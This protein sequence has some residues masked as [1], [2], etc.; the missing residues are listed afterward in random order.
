[1]PGGELAYVAGR[2]VAGAVI[3]H[4][5]FRVPLLRSQVFQDS[6]QRPADA[7]P[8]VVS[9]YNNAVLRLCRLQT[10]IGQGELYRQAHA[11]CSFFLSMAKNSGTRLGSQN[12]FTASSVMVRLASSWVSAGLYG[13]AVRNA[14]YTSTT[15]STRASS[16]MLYPVSWSG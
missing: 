14:S 11:A 13:R 3:H 8:L 15:C 1:M 2:V 10:G 4:H 6:L 5:H 7:R 12:P 9:R 16:G